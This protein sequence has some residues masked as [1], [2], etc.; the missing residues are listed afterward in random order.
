M[1]DM[2][3]R[4]ATLPGGC[5]WSGAS[6]DRSFV[7][8]D[9]TC[10]ERKFSLTL[11]HPDDQPNATTCTDRFALDGTGLSP[12]LLEALVTRIRARE[13]SVRWESAQVGVAPLQARPFPVAAATWVS[14]AIVASTLVAFTV[15]F[16]ATTRG[17]L[18][19]R[20][21]AAA[22]VVLTI[23]LSAAGFG[24]LR[25]ALVTG[26]QLLSLS[27]HLPNPEPAMLRDACLGVA[28]VALAPAWMK[29]HGAR[30]VAA[31]LTLALL[32]TWVVSINRAPLTMF[33][34]LS[35]LSTDVAPYPLNSRG[36]RGPEFELEKAP[37]V[38]R[39]V[40]IG[41]SFVEGDGIT[42]ETQTLPRQLQRE[43]ERRQPQTRLEVINLGI[44]GNNLASHVTAAEEAARL[45]QPDA[46]VV[47]LTL[48]NDLSPI[49][50]QVLRSAA[51]RLS[52]FSL[53]QSMFGDAVNLAVLRATLPGSTLTAQELDFTAR[54]AARLSAV[55]APM[56]V[57]SFHRPDPA[58]RERF[59][60]P[61][62]SPDTMEETDFIPGDGHPT[63][64]GAG[65]FAVMIADAL[66]PVLR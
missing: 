17:R 10:G 53:A 9:Y 31:T 1:A 25:A 36:F 24:V 7:R 4:G 56:V 6:I 23:V 48:N 20:L 13:R 29:R 63:S 2:L 57:F 62:V 19:E 27:S 44:A 14:A 64:T 12:E 3:G 58:V 35:T 38:R 52:A 61:L 16:L 42:D 26:A 46:L 32:G 40:V 50:G 55:R 15:R 47:C 45:L 66:E 54:E 41:D 30:V 21:P 5:V 28:L 39:V 60:Q 11:R 33:G 34:S 49:D 59:K 22:S 43:L 37:G 18:S 51:R 65:R 8:S